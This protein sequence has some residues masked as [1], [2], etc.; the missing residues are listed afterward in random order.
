MRLEEAHR[1]LSFFRL[2][3]LTGFLWKLLSGRLSRSDGWR[4]LKGRVVQLKG[5][6][7][8][9]RWTLRRLH[10]GLTIT[11]RWVDGGN[12][13]QYVRTESRMVLKGG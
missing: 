10:G 11:T 12:C 3:G 6:T 8:V 2:V 4:H 9:D 1:H 13:R 5:G 7:E